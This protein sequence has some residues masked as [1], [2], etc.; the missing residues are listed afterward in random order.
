MTF[1]LQGVS[2]ATSVVIFNDQEGHAQRPRFLGNAKSNTQSSKNNNIE[3]QDLT[4]KSAIVYPN[5]LPC[6]HICRYLIDDEFAA[7]SGAYVHVDAFL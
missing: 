1:H 6:I 4:A 7:E 3:K 5:T 2:R